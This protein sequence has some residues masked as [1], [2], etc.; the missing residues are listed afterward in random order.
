MAVDSALLERALRLFPALAGAPAALRERL[1]AEALTA[2]VPA[3]ARLFDERSPCRG[4]PLVL[5]GTVRVAKLA[6]NGREI[7]L[8]RVEPGECCVL[9]TGCLLGG[10]DYT[11]TG[12]AESEVE[13]LAVPPALFDALVDADAA[14]RQQVFRLFAD[15]LAELTVLVEEV[16]FR[17]LDQRLAAWLATRG[18]DVRM[19]HQAL[20]EELG[21]VR[22]IVSRLLGHFAQ[23][24][25]VSLGRGH[26]RVLDP[27]GLARLARSE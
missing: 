14:F 12:T 16:A 15:R 17:R 26:V 23:Q 27:G 3:G 2:R 19:S 9:S 11:A 8:Y 4:F 7:V 25:L 24:G 13:L 21:S 18:P 5:A 22:E 1:A 10:T 6:P 20:A